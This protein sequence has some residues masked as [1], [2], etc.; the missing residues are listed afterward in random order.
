MYIGNIVKQKR[1]KEA[2]LGMRPIPNN[3][4][5]LHNAGANPKITA[6]KVNNPKRV[7]RQEVQSGCGKHNNVK[8]FTHSMCI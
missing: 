8:L 7:K 2:R 5:N 6:A 3:Q 4:G 1:A